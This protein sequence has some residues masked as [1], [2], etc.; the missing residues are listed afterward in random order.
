MFAIPPL[1]ESVEGGPFSRGYFCEDLDTCSVDDGMEAYIYACMHARFNAW[2]GYL[3]FLVR[4]R[5]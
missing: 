5:R 1:V 3:G 2:R 4:R